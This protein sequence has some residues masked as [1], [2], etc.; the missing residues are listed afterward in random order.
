MGWSN[1]IDL[2][3]PAIETG[4]SRPFDGPAPAP[5]PHYHYGM[6]LNFDGH[7]LDA[8]GLEMPTKEGQELDIRAF[9]KVVGFRNEDGIRSVTVQLTRIKLE[10]EDAE[11]EDE[12]KD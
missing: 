10:N 4:E 3:M 8:C 9:G 1:W 11:T 6:R 5:G 7:C 12:E 2:A